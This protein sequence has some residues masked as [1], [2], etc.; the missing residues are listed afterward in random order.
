MRGHFTIALLD[1]LRPV[2]HVVANFVGGEIATR[3]PRARFEADDVDSGFG[4][5]QRGDTTGCAQ[6]NDH[7]FRRRQSSRHG[8]GP[9]SSA[10]ELWPW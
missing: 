10:R 3:Q 9:P 5:W 6:P 8:L 7:D 4:D 2:A 1:S